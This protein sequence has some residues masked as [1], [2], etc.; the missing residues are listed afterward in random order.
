MGAPIEA[1]LSS[2]V[3]WL[4]HD[5]LGMP[6]PNFNVDM[7]QGGGNGGNSSTGGPWPRDGS[8]VGGQNGQQ[9]AQSPPANSNAA[10]QQRLQLGIRLARADWTSTRSLGLRRPTGSPR[11]RRRRWRSSLVRRSRGFLRWRSPP[12]RRPVGSQPRRLSFWSWPAFLN[13]PCRL[14]K[15]ITARIAAVPTCLPT[16]ELKSP[17]I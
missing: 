8:N 3:L 9:V 14:K 12:P 11:S 15:S 6:R 10:P 1:G 17:G 2:A 4:N 13:W 16:T 7:G 5:L